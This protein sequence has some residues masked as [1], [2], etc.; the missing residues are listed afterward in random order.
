[1]K[2]TQY[3][4]WSDSFEHQNKTTTWS[5]GYFQKLIET[6]CKFKT[7]LTL[8][9]V[10]V[11]RG[12]HIRHLLDNFGDNINKIYGVDPH[13]SGYNDKKDFFSK[14]Q[15]EEFEYLH[16]WVRNYCNDEKFELIRSKSQYVAPSFEDH[17]IDAIYIDGDHTYEGV[18]TDIN[19][20][21]DKVKIG[22]LISGDDFDQFKGTKQAVKELI[23]SYK[24][25]DNNTWYWIKE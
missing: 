25:Y 18:K 3:K 7:N 10:G 5:Y 15:Q 11:G 12:G 6:E 17:S 4:K 16:V 23:P 13:L 9:E 14:K 19:A 8:V 20:W 21:I 24:L 22:G 1:M 2:K